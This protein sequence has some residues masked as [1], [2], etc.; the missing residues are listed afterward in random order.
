MLDRTLEM[1][2]FRWAHLATLRY[3]QYGAESLR[4]SGLAVL[5]LGEIT[6]QQSNMPRRKP[7]MALH[8]QLRIAH[9]SPRSLVGLPVGQ[10]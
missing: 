6:D 2:G 4:D 7:A 8:D 9:A 5:N 10:A 1:R 3:F